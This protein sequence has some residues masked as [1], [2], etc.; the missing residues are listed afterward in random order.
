MIYLCLIIQILFLIFFSLS[1]KDIYLIRSD[2]YYKRYQLV[3]LIVQVLCIIINI[4]FIF[5][6]KEFMIYIFVVQ[7]YLAGLILVFYSVKAKKQIFNKLISII[8]EDE[9][10][11]LEAR[12]IRRYLLKNYGL[13]YDV[14]EIEK[15]LSKIKSKT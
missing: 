14:K 12:E 13:L 1:P 3:V 15:C 8:N 4:A 11:F 10:L 2:Y 5:I 7:I 9:L 6:N